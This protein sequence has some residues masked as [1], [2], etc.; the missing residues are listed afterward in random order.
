MGHRGRQMKPSWSTEWVPGQPKLHR[1]TMSWKTKTSRQINNTIQPKQKNKNKNGT[2]KVCLDILA[3]WF[4]LFVFVF[5]FV[6]F[7][8]FLRQSQLFN[9]KHCVSASRVLR[10]HGHAPTTPI[11]LALRGELQQVL[12]AKAHLLLSYV[13]SLHTGSCVTFYA[14]TF[15]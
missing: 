4:C 6:F 10:W 2:W 13:S 7:I 3:K 9:S 15:L 11:I 5:C 12:C 8:F 1:E 14:L